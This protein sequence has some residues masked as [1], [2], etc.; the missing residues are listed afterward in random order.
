MEVIAFTVLRVVTGLFFVFSGF[1]KL[2]NKERHASLVATLESDKI[3]LISFNQWF[4]PSIELLA[5]LGVTFGF[6]TPLSAIGLVILLSVATVTDGLKRVASYKPIDAADYADD[7]L[8]LPEVIYIFVL[9]YIAVHG[10]TFPSIDWLIF[11][12]LGLL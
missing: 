5:G 6:L 7:V 12:A 2:F 4:V 1:H 10:V 3:P 11:N 8:Y 9:L